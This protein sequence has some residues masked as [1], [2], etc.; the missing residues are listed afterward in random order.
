MSASSDSSH[1]LRLGDVTL[2]LSRRCHIMGILNVTPDSFSDGGT[3]ADAGTAVEH[4]LRME[5][6]GAAIIDIGG[7]STRPGAP[8]VSREEELARVLPVIEG[9]RR[10]S[11]VPVSVDTRKA[12]VAAAAIAAGADMINDVS[13]LRFDDDMAALA[14]RP[15]LPVVLMHMRGEPATMQEQPVYDDVVE[16]VLAFFR[17]RI[18]YSRSRGI[19]QILIDPGIGFGKTLE[20]NVTLLREL[21]RFRELQCPLLIGTSRKSFLGSI[22]GQPVGGRLPGSIASNLLA[23]R[24]GA[25]ILRVHDV[26]EIRAALDV[27]DAIEHGVE[28]SHAV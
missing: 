28:V 22:T 23:C 18:A 4:A 26:A 19:T 12:S 14:A 7:E 5:E 1:S 10:E 13:A 20:H 15:H 27:T 17:E 24:N 25:R 9:L 11:S 3:H 2:D 8:A 16:E 21:S 6:A